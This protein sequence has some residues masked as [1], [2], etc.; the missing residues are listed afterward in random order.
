MK[1]MKIKAQSISLFLFFSVLGFVIMVPFF[2]IL[3]AS[4][5]ETQNLFRSGFNMNFLNE[6]LTTE[7]YIY[8]FTGDHQ[9]FIWYSNSLLIT[10]M[11]VLVV[12]VLSAGV[13][14]G[15]AMY[16]F[17]FKNILFALLLVQMMV[18]FEIIMLPLYQTVMTIGLLDSYAGI[19]L[20]GIVSPFLVLF[21]RQYLSSTP[22][23]Y[24]DAARIDGCNEYRIFFMIFLPIMRPALSAMG[25]F[26]AIG[27]WNG[28]LWP[29]LVL[30]SPNKFTLPIGLASLVG[31]YGDNFKLL[32]AGSAFA[33]LPVLILF[34][35]FR[36]SFTEAMTAGGIKG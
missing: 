34:I 21:F 15:F 35:I 27:A 19:I 3:I 5:K 14:Y 26:A 31:P 16:R 1:K 22:K 29:L 12:L 33:I 9:Y 20:P 23:D 8:I 25:I 13:A 17:R 24:L 30:S 10:F 18:P 36:K 11:Q 7:N 2:A 28:F 4:F 32:I 6:K